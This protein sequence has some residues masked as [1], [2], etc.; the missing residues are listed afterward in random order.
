[1]AYSG[2]PEEQRVKKQAKDAEYRTA[3]A[4][5]IRAAQAAWRI[6]NADKKRQLD[7]EYRAKNRAILNAKQRER[8]ST[9][10]LD[11]VSRALL[12]AYQRSWRRRNPDKAR[13]G[14]QRGY[15]KNKDKIA[16]RNVAWR[17]AHP[18]QKRALDRAWKRAHPELMKQGAQRWNANNPGRRAQAKRAWRK[19]HPDK[20]RI[21]DHTGRTRRRARQK[22][23]AR[24]DLTHQ[25]WLYIQASQNHS[26]AYCG[27]RCKGHLTQDH[28]TPFA[29]GGSNTLHNVIGAC[30]QCNKRKYT[31]PAPVLVQPLLL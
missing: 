21:H 12:N 3:H 29:K 28:I 27:K 17:N 22:G 19:A 9:K 14:T 18:E 16:A 31:H 4:E 24:N 30:S 15:A 7:A 6:K 5:S 2:T 10:R 1:M 26:C 25:Q 23:D 11:P 20:A 13:A 8:E